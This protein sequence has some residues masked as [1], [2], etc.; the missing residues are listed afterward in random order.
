MDMR[1]D[2]EPNGRAKGS[3]IEQAR[4]SQIVDTAIRTIAQRGY[5]QASL[6]EIAREAGISKGVISYHFEGKDDYIMM[7]CNKSPEMSIKGKGQTAG[8][9]KFFAYSDFEDY[10]EHDVLFKLKDRVRLI[11][12]YRNGAI[13]AQSYGSSRRH[14]VTMVQA[15]CSSSRLESTARA[16]SWVMSMVA[17]RAASSAAVARYSSSDS[18]MRCS[19]LCRRRLCPSLAMRTALTRSRRTPM[20]TGFLR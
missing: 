2:S 12:L 10:N 15:I 19:A 3:F 18:R 16:I 20:G 13:E 6:A 7:R 11:E 8:E 9:V 14:R 17:T 5:S 4:R 1:S